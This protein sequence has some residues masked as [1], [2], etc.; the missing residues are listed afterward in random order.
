[1]TDVYEKLA[2]HLDSLPAGYPS[3]ETGLELRI[4]KRL[5]SPDEAQIATALTMMPEPVA[6]IAARLDKDEAQLT[7]ALET[8]AKKGLIFRIS[9]KET[10]LYSAAQFVVGIWEYH[11]NRSRRRSDP[12]CQRIHA[13]PDEKELAEDQDQT[14]AGGAGGQK[15]IG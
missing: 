5:F 1:M 13:H 9:K 3:T 11:V 7:V 8:M 4:L 6:G 15:R 14:D 2:K 12:G 10:V